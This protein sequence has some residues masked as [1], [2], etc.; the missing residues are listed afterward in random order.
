MRCNK[1][2]L[3]SDSWQVGYKS[4]T[5]IGIRSLMFK[6]ASGEA[7]INI[8]FQGFILLP[9]PSVFPFHSLIPSSF[10]KAVHRYYLNFVH[11]NKE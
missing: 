4:A 11:S 8:T 1:A 9:F 2:D 10:I 3:Q 6:P 5:F 7:K